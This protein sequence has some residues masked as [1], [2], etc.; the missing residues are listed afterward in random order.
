MKT[1]LQ[2]SGLEI[3]RWKGRA[4][5]VLWAWPF[6]H[7][8]MWNGLVCFLS[9]LCEPSLQ[10]C[11]SGKC[12]VQWPAAV[13]SP[14]HAWKSGPWGRLGSLSVTPPR[15]RLLRLPHFAP[16]FLAA[17]WGRVLLWSPAVWRVLLVCSRLPP[18]ASLPH[19]GG[20][21][22]LAFLLLLP[23]ALRRLC[24]PSGV[25]ADFSSLVKG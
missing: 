16:V 20:L 4:V 1:A 15:P 3:C 13:R 9:L 10:L 18:S 22:D 5:S 11:S 19:R 23:Q 7:G 24:S 17:L 14:R 6:L 21:T 12:R 25:L 2:E 8:K